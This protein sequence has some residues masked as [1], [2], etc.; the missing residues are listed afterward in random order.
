MSN[1]Q[2]NAQ[3]SPAPAT[4]GGPDWV[5][6]WA[7]P[8]GAAVVGSQYDAAVARGLVFS[9]RVGTLTTPL[10]GAGAVVA[11]TP[12]LLVDI[13][14]GTSIRPVYLSVQYETVGTTLLLETFA[15]I[16]STL[17]SKSGGNSVT[18]VSLRNSGGGSSN[19][20]ATSIATATAQT[21]VVHEFFRDGFQLAEDMAATEDGWASRKFVWRAGVD[22]PAPLI[23]G[24]ASVFVYAAAQNP[25]VF[26]N[27]IW[28]EFQANEY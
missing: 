9:A 4:G 8:H 23:K 17:G 5:K 28:E 20:T 11:T 15:S 7:T 12:D 10:T 18:P 14:S 25:T 2:I 22:G 6:Q 13:P 1:Q 16:S 26:I 3:A 27:F 19:C 21:G 24:N